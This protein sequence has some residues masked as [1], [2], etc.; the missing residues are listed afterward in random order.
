MDYLEKGG[1]N[2]RRW[3][4]GLYIPPELY[5]VLLSLPAPPTIESM[6]F[7]FMKKKIFLQRQSSDCIKVSAVD[8]V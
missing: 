1:R 8:D 3:E 7:D 4:R 6:D 2:G 5:H